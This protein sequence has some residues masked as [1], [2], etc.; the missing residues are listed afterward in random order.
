VRQKVSSVPGVKEA[1]IELVWEP[2]WDQGRMTDVARLQL[3]WM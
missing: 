3:G 1:N 2:P